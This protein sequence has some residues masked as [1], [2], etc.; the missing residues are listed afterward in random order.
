MKR[1]PQPDTRIDRRARHGDVRQVIL[2]HLPLTAT[3]VRRGVRVTTIAEGFGQM[4]NKA[5]RKD[6]AQMAV[7]LS[8]STQKTVHRDNFVDDPAKVIRT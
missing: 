6:R 8:G 7:V 5:R 2:G 3:A 4:T 1:I